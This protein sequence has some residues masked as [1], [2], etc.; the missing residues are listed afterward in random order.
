[1]G[2]LLYGVPPRRQN[3]GDYWLNSTRTSENI[4]FVA[5]RVR[6]KTAVS[7]DSAYRPLMLAASGRLEPRLPGGR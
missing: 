6:G 7:V 1:M 4:R 5:T 3:V 2:A